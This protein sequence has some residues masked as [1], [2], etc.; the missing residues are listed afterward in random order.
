MHILNHEG[1]C[2]SVYRGGQPSEYKWLRR[3][4]AKRR[5]VLSLHP[6]WW[7]Q[8]SQKPMCLFMEEGPDPGPQ[9]QEKSCVQ[10]LRRE[11]A[12]DQ[13]TDSLEEEQHS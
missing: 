13:N 3:M 2:P 7:L 12:T 8:N 6:G 1:V 4:L 9:S 10:G 11:G 5:S